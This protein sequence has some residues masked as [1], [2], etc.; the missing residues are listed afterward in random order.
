MIKGQ[1]NSFI[2]EFNALIPKVQIQKIKF[3]TIHFNLT[4]FLLRLIDT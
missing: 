2:D 3:V 1:G 4:I